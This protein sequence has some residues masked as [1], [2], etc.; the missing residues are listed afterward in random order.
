MILE[1]S[2]YRLV[3]FCSSACLA[4]LYNMSPEWA[5]PSHSELTLDEHHPLL[6]LGLFS[7]SRWRQLVP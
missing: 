2:Q 4:H 7:D 3:E 5:F 6:S 1:T